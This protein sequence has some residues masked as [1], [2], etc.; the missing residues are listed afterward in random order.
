LLRLL[1]AAAAIV[2][3]LVDSL[4]TDKPSGLLVMRRPLS[5]GLALGTAL[6]LVNGGQIHTM[7]PGQI[8]IRPER[9][10]IE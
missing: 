3:P 1:P 10:A 6:G 2:L 4:Q 7:D 5:F 9:L 8:A